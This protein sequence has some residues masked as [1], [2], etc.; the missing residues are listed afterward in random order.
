MV[1]ASQAI[2]Q[3]AR[4]CHASRVSS[5]VFFRGSVPCDG[6]CAQSSSVFSATKSSTLSGDGVGVILE[7]CSP[8]EG[9]FASVARAQSSRHPFAS[10][11]ETQTCDV[12]EKSTQHVERGRGSGGGEQ[13]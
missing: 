10:R 11:V 2:Q 5:V 13:F 4:M 6:S 9:F 8:Q 3:Q 12:G 7:P 1:M